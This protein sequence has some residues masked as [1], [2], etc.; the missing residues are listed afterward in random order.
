M[1]PN[2]LIVW[3]QVISLIIKDQF[4]TIQNLQWSRPLFH[5]AVTGQELFFAVSYSK[6]AL[7]ILSLLGTKDHYH[8]DFTD[9]VVRGSI[10]LNKGALSWPADPPVVV[11]APVAPAAAAAQAKAAEVEPNYFGIYMKDAAL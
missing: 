2:W 10:V 8:L 6:P 9:D 3:V 4:Y 5:K 11:V 1:I 7:T